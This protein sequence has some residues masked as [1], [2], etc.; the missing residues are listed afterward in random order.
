MQIKERYFFQIESVQNWL[1]CICVWTKIRINAESMWT[2]SLNS[3]GQQF[4]QYQQ[5]ELK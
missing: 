4:H 1:K 5:S 2:E 3:N